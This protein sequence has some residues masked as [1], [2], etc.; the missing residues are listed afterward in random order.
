M[1]KNMLLTFKS[2]I[3]NEETG[4]DTIEFMTTADFVK[5]NNKYYITF[6]DLET[7]ETNDTKTTLKVEDDKITLIRFGSNNAQFIFK[8]GKE[9]KSH[10]ET[11]YGAFSMA[12]FSEYV[13]IDMNDE[14]GDLSVL[15]DIYL[16][17][18]KTQT[19]NLKINLKLPN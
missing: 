10:Y 19:N 2:D 3:N 12:V 17:G 7:F 11:P 1:G 13:S 4:K 6:S 8:Q 15:Y 18:L 14:G 16:N 9:Y 5:K